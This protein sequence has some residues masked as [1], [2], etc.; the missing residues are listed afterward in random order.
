MSIVDGFV[1]E[2]AWTWLGVPYKV[3]GRNR[4]GIDCV[5]LPIKVGHELGLTDYDFTDYPRYPN[6]VQFIGGLRQHMQEV[7]LNQIGN[8]HLLILR[9]PVMPCHCGILKVQPTGER[10]VIHAYEPAKKV[11]PQDLRTMG[12]PVRAFRFAEKV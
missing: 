4:Y 5:G 1:A 12:Q 6:P 8:G 9:G 3:R 2:Q 7:P 10:L 11:I